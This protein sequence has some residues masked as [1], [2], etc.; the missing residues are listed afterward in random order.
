M[1]VVIVG[2]LRESAAGERRV[3]PDP[4]AVIRLTKAGRIELV[5]AGAGV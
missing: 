3:A 4:S 5:E 1:A 2:A